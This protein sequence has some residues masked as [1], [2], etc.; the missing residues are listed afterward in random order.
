MAQQGRDKQ[1]EVK[2]QEQLTKKQLKKQQK[3][4][5]KQQV[6]LLLL[7]LL[8]ICARVAWEMMP[9]DVRFA[10]CITSCPFPPRFV[11]TGC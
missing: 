2:K 1:K 11:P 7:L 6:L 3:K 9:T 4:L 10:A 5:E 8:P